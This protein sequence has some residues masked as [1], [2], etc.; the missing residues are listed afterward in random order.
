M[1]RAVDAAVAAGRPPGGDPWTDH[2]LWQRRHFVYYA[3]DNALECFAPQVLKRLAALGHSFGAC[4][5]SRKGGGEGGR[6]GREGRRA[7]RYEGPAGKA[8]PWSQPGLTRRGGRRGAACRQQC[9]FLPPCSSPPRSVPPCALLLLLLAPARPA[10]FQVPHLE[11]PELRLAPLHALLLASEPSAVV[12]LPQRPGGSAGGN[13][14]T[15]GAG[16]SDEGGG[17]GGGD[18]ATTETLGTLATNVGR[19]GGGGS[20]AVRGPPRHLFEITFPAGEGGAPGKPPLLCCADTAEARARWMDA[21]NK[22]K[23]G[24]PRGPRSVPPATTGGAP[25]KAVQVHTG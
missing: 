25:A 12:A 16:D 20:A 17:E 4:L 24:V 13:G 21:I 9:I 23:R 14:A 7:R 5:L 2:G 18:D 10:P 3:A 22:N 6:G 11:T 15:D 1:Q 8:V 19:G